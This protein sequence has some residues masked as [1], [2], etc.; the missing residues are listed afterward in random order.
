MNAPRSTPAHL[1]HQRGVALI[2]ALIIVA[3]V[4]SLSVYLAW[5][6]SLGIRRTHNLLAQDRT[7]VLC[8][9]AEAW[10]A[11]T[12]ADNR[13]K[14]PKS[15]NLQQQWATQLPPIAVGDA[16]VNGAIADLQGRLNLNSLPSRNADQ[17]RFARMVSNAHGAT[18]V[19]R[20]V[21]DWSN[22][23]DFNSSGYYQNLQPPYRAA[24][25]PFT[26]PSML[27]MVQGF[28]THLTAALA[29]DLIALPG[30]TPINVNTA[31]AGVLR[32][33]GL[34]AAE[35]TSLIERRAKTPFNSVT[36]FLAS[37][38]FLG[39]QVDA[40][41]LGIDSHYF[42]LQSQASIGRARSILFSVLS[43]QPNGKVKVLL[44]SRNV[45]P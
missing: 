32:G 17:L 18:D 6:L 2:T 1:A 33:L 9:G 20:S 41:G 31:T 4:T 38:E 7:Y 39:K 22:A 30:A 11:Q 8:L 37:P 24:R 3:I 12:L 42:L 15:V 21:V 26:V 14:N 13:L 43:V 36:Q 45:P 35:A 5:D 10:A 23:Q 27:R 28:D 25:Q 19:V 29:P 44:R 34:S 40:T 16:L